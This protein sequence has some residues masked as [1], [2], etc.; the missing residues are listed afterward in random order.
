MQPSLRTLATV[1]NYHDLV[2][3]LR[4]RADEMRVSRETI[5]SAAKLQKG[6][7]AKMLSSTPVKGVG[8]SSLGP[9]LSMLGL[10]LVVVEARTA[11]QAF[12]TI[13][14]HDTLGRRNES[15]VRYPARKP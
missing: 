4:A 14:A 5:D 15:Q 9:L 3:V 7:S 6:Y 2:A 12:N 1:R 10:E 13:A 8:Q 11:D